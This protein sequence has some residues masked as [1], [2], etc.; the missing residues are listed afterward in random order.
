MDGS[1]EVKFGQRQIL[2]AR[3]LDVIR[4]AFNKLRMKTAIF[5]RRGLIGNGSA[6]I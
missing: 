1:G 5:Q 3:Y 2:R 4:A 6:F